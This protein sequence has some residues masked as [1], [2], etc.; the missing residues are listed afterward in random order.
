MCMDGASKFSKHLNPT[1]VEQ[2]KSDKPK[3]HFP[4]LVIGT[5]LRYITCVDEQNRPM[6][7]PDS[8][9]DQSNLKEIAN[10]IEPNVKHL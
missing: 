3:V 5:W 1:I 8:L 7:I 4:S 9:A 6:I 2:L 10:K